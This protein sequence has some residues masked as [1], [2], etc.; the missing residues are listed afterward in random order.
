MAVRTWSSSGSGLGVGAGNG[1]LPP[2]CGDSLSS[3][4][5]YENSAVAVGKCAYENIPAALSAGGHGVGHGIGAGLGGLNPEFEEEIEAD[6]TAMYE[7]TTLQV[8]VSHAKN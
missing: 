8:H 4:S 6:S 3:S 5:S 1:T 7:A 2:E